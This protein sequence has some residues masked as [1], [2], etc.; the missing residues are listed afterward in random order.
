MVKAGGYA[1]MSVIKRWQGWGWLTRLVI[2]RALVVRNLGSSSICQGGDH[3]GDLQLVQSVSIGDVMISTMEVV[4]EMPNW[5]RMRLV[6]QIVA[7]CMRNTS[8]PHI[9]RRWRMC[10][11]MVHVLEEKWNAAETKL[12]R[13]DIGQRFNILFL[14]YEWGLFKSGSWPM[15]QC[16]GSSIEE[17]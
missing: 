1:E 2:W 6:R 13:C 7:V 12:E 15:E 10:L 11:E 17:S 16:L 8:C 9:S 5:S 14:K 4:L 3:K